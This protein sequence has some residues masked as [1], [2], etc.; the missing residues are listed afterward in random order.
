MATNRDPWLDNAKMLLITAVVVGHMMVLLPGDDAV[1]DHVYDAVYV[2]HMPAFV[3]VSG[4]LSQRVSWSRRSLT[5]LVT[6]LVAPFVVFTLILHA[7]FYARVGEPIE[8]PILLD[9]FWALWFLCALVLW[10]LAS[11][12]LRFSPVMI[13]L[14]FLVALATPM[15]DQT[16]ELALNR[17]LQ[18]LPFFVVGL[19]LRKEWLDH[20]KR[21]VARIL[22]VIGLVAIWVMAAGFDERTGSSWLYYNGSYDGLGVDTA[23]GLVTRMTVFGWSFAGTFALLALTPTTRGWWTNIGTQSMTVYLGHTVILKALQYDGYFRDMEPTAATRQG[24]LIAL[25]VVGVLAATPVVRSLRWLTDPVG[26]VKDLR[27]DLA[28]RP[29]GPTSEELPAAETRPAREPAHA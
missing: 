24:V 6:T 26:A 2:I 20:L 17:V 8:T 4:Y 25:L 9:P 27:A 21:P 3:L 12:V 29:E 22:G 7:M 16:P 13:P 14:S 5:S 28:T 19:H 23:E 18:F 11:P 1:R 15:V 10:R